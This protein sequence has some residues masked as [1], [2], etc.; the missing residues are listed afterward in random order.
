MIAELS[1]SGHGQQKTRLA[2]GST[3]LWVQESG[4]GQRRDGTDLCDFNEAAASILFHV[5]IEALVLD[6]QHFSGQLLLPAG[7]RHLTCGSRVGR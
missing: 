1:G 6:L 3:D 2:T 4:T 5:Q 7:L